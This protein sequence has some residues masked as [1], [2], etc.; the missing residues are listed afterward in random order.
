MSSLIPIV[1]LIGALLYLVRW[2]TTRD[3][4][5]LPPGPPALPIIGNLHQAPS[6]HAWLQFHEW[7]KQYGPIFKVQ[8]GRDTIIVL[9]DY[10]TAHELLNR[11]SANFS[12]RPWKPFAADCLYKGLHILL[13]PYDAQYKLHQKMEAPLLNAGVSRL[14]TPIQD[15]ESCQLVQELFENTDF[16]FLLHRF[17]ASVAY[18]LVFGF[19]IRTGHEQEMGKAEIVLERLVK[20]FKPGM[21]IVDTFPFLNRLPVWLA[22]WKRLAEGWYQFEAT[23]HKSNVRKALESPHWNFSKHLFGCKEAQGMDELEVAFNGGILSDAAIHTTGHTLEMFVMVTVNH[24]EQARLVQNE[25]DHTVGRDRLPDSGDSEKLPYT[26]AFINEVLRWR[27][28]APGG[29]PHSNLEEDTYMGYRI[30]KGS[31]VFGSAWSIHMDE[32]T[33]GD[34]EVFRPERWLENPGLPSVAFGFGR[35]ACAGQHIARQSLFLVIS[36]LLWAFDIKKA[37]D[38]FGNEV[39]VDDMA[40]TDYFTVGPE[41]FKARFLPRDERVQMVMREKWEK[42]EKDVGVIL[43]SANARG[44]FARK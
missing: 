23:L 44:D 20:A 25:L 42:L 5:P 41:P 39:D 29:V 26:M 15:L 18:A 35:R 40:L 1:V 4:L 31:V 17:A 30:P 2:Y 43:D 12:S 22:P 34:P 10:W 7:T 21:W 16:A 13:R 6:K 36:R 32:K 38:K 24:P 19:R 28:I 33:Y 37:L 14:Y 8:F 3:R 27:P 9:G 11:R